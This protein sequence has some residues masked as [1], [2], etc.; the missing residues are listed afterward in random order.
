M[1]IHIYFFPQLILD[2]I[3]LLSLSLFIFYLSQ[4]AEILS[5]ASTVASDDDDE[6][7]RDET[8]LEDDEDSEVEMDKASETGGSKG[9]EDD[10]EGIGE[11]YSEVY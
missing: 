3:T 2:F 11:S 10:E 8:V 6:D 7:D 1:E 5:Q 9:D 4:G